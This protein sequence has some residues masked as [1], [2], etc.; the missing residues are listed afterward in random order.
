MR[1]YGCCK[2]IPITKKM[3]K[4][5]LEDAANPPEGEIEIGGH[6]YTQENYDFMIK[7]HIPLYHVRD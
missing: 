4:L 2:T 6:F 5:H 3:M 7:H 1:K